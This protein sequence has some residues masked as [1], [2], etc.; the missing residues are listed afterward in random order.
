MILSF[1]GEDSV[2]F[3]VGSLLVLGATVCWGFE[4]NCTRSISDKS[5]Y[6]IVTIKGFGSGISSL[7]IAFILGENLPEIRFILSAVLLE[8]AAY[9]LSIF[10]YIRAQKSLGAANTSAF[11]SIAPFIGVFLSFV[12]LRETLTIAYMIALL[13]MIAGT[14]F[15]VFD[16]FSNNE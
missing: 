8:F 16:T 5:T 6:Q 9:G 15:V 7:I 3:S 4:T 2:S 12:F 13:I 10:T 14:V 11:Y 1:N